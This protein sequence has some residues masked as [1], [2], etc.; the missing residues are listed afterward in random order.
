MPTL[1]DVRRICRKLP[2]TEEGEGEQFGIGV[3]NKGKSRGLVWSWRERIEPKK[4]RVPNE[5]V[6]A[7]RTPGL[8]AK[9]VILE[10]DPVKFFTEPHY[11]NYPAVLVRLEEIGLD[12]LEDLI[13][14]AWRCCAPL[15]VVREWDNREET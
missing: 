2:D 9:E 4:A 5:K 7:V 12:E 8:A 3:L 6:L 10:S 14:G 15:K 1:D 11:Q 13:I